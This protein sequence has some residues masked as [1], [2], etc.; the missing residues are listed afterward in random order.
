[1]FLLVSVVLLIL[2]R[3]I[4]KKIFSFG[5]KN[6]NMQEVGRIAAVIQPIDTVQG[7]GRVRLDGVD[8]IAISQTGA[9]IPNHTSVRVIAVDGS[10]LI[11]APLEDS[12]P[13][14]APSSH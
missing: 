11:V 2:T 7:T 5:V 6:T 9:P 4:A 10:K 13:A 1:M 8:W 3:P 14:A 12:Q